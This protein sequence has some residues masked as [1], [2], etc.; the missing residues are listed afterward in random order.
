MRLYNKI[1]IQNNKEKI[2]A[3]QNLYRQ[4]NREKIRAYDKTY[5]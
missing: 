3:K 4:N 1:W 2:R 5:K